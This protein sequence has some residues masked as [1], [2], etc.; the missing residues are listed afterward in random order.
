MAEGALLS[1]HFMAMG[2]SAH[3]RIRDQVQEME[4]ED[5]RY[6]ETLATNLCIDIL[7]QCFDNFFFRMRKG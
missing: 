4:M 2:E 6:G 5:E 1:M 7:L 3:K